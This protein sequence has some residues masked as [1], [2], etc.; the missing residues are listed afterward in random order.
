MRISDWSSDVCSSDLPEAHN[1]LRIVGRSR[2]MIISG[3]LNVYPRE[4]EHAALESFLVREAAVVGIPSSRWGEEVVMA[5]V[6]ETPEATDVDAVLAHL[7]QRLAPYK[8]PKQ[9]RVEI[10][11]AHV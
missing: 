6:P 5:I 4:I 1:Y 10:G 7:R 8:V 11:R 9:I 3:G 2:E